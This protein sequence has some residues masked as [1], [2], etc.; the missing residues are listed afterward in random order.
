[1]NYGQIQERITEIKELLLD[2]N[3]DE[4]KEKIDGK[5]SKQEILGHLIDSASNN[6]KRF[7]MAQLKEDLIFDGY[8]QDEWVSVQKYNELNWI[9]LVDLWYHFNSLIIHVC[10]NIPGEELSKPRI[11]HNLD[12]IAWQR[13]P[14]DQPTTLGYF[15][16]DYFGHME[17]HI[18]QILS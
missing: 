14:A 15:I 8:E 17:H 12:K 2:I 6:H 1:M 5:W 11:K 16:K 10:K 13:V 7:V 4:V 9:F 3:A 18:A